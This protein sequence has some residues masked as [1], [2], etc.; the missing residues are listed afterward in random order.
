ML[1]R[2]NIK[3]Y[4]CYENHTVDLKTLSIIVGKN[5]AGKS[6]L[7]ESLR[8]VALIANR[9][10]NLAF[11]NHPEWIDLPDYVK[12][13]I[14]SLKQIEFSFE[15]LFY[16]YS[17]PPAIII[18]YFS[19]KIKIE[20]YIGG[21][22]KIFGLIYSRTGTLIKTKGDAAKVNIQNINILPQISPLQQ[23]E[24]TLNYD[25]VR[26]NMSSFRTSSHF[27]N[28]INYFYNYY[29]EFKSI[30][31]TTWKGLQIKSFQGRTQFTG[32][33]IQLIVRDNEFVAE[34]GWMGHGLQM[35]LQT[36]W[37]L[38]R[39]PKD[40]IIILDEPDV[41]MHADLQRKLIRFLKNKY[42]QVI[43]ATHS[44]E[45]ITE[46]E[47]ENI[48]VIDRRNRKSMY[49]S[50][51]PAVQKLAQN[52]GSI[53]N[54]ELARLWSAK[55]LLLVEGKDIDILKRLQ[56]TLCEDTDEP[57]D[58]IPRMS[59]GGWGGWNYAIGTKMLL[60]NA[61]DNSIKVYCL[62]DS[63]YHTKEEIEDRN[64][65]AKKK[66]VNLHIWKRKEIENYLIVPKAI[67][68]IINE[69][70]EIHIEESK[71][72]SIVDGIIE[73]LKSDVVNCYTD[74]LF[75][76]YRREKKEIMP[77]TVSKEA[78][79]YINSI[80]DRKIEIVSGKEV[81]RRL[82]DFLEKEFNISFSTKRLALELRKNEID[83]E[84]KVII[85]KIENNKEF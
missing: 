50:N 72:A 9:Y 29:T 84:L 65:Q 74:E 40:S 47:P 44:I 75:V 25:Y 6:T 70:K 69:S 59:I 1:S 77:S 26:A 30:S 60:K 39:S 21:E 2:L 4:R 36:M 19:N 52:I 73:N 45:I 27:R 31:E 67:T 42:K 11:R 34:I 3:N 54:I 51:F 49:A 57:F 62:L 83:E 12:G 53:Q 38:A 8:L 56:D 14:P 35:W 55:K 58:I 78:K 7:I 64:D 43:I 28:Q 85:T 71:I 32:K 23:S 81:I 20:V 76:Q 22:D 37:F 68:R 41:Y 24:V 82:N 15:N 17:D 61:G 48:L 80:W 5:N 10:K 79:K 66:N 33:N 18:A 63:D 13:V 46:V 16:F